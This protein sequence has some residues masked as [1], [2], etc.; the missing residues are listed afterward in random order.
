[1]GKKSLDRETIKITFS[2][3]SEPSPSLVANLLKEVVYEN[4]LEGC[5]MREHSGPIP[6]TIYSFE[7][8]VRFL[9]D[10]FPLVDLAELANWVEKTIGDEELAAK[11]KESVKE[12]PCTTSGIR[13]AACLMA[14][15]FD[16]VQNLDIA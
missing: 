8:A 4:R 1:M 10:I 12:E 5:L 3:L 9:S 11:I 15:R 2:E 13:I 14:Q 6:V 7:E 16:Q